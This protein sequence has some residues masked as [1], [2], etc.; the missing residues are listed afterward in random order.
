MSKWTGASHLISI[1]LVYVCNPSAAVVRMSVRKFQQN[2]LEAW[3]GIVDLF[4]GTLQVCEIDKSQ[5]PP[6][7]YARSCNVVHKRNRCS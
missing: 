7:D 2:L 5:F 3:K 1:S 6:S 4:Y